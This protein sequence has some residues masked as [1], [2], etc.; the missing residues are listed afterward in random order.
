MNTSLETKREEGRQTDPQTKTDRRT[1]TQR[2]RETG[3]DKN[4][5]T[6]RQAGRMERQRKRL[7]S[8]E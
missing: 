7:S 2:Q 3:R 4:L 1:D 6:D 5:N 8:A